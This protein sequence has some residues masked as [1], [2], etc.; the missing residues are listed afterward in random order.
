MWSKNK[1]VVLSI[2]VC[3][4]FAAVLTAGVLVVPGRSSS[5]FSFTG[6]GR[7]KTSGIWWCCSMPASIPVPSLPM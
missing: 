4:V 6:A 1:S 5:G 7:G 2:V 3:F